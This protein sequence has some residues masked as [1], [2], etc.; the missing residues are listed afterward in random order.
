M[1]CGCASISHVYRVY[2]TEYN[3]VITTVIITKV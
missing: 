2:V 1:Q 3:R